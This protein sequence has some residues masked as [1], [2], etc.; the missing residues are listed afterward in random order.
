MTHHIHHVNCDIS[1]QFFHASAKFLAFRITNCSQRIDMFS[2]A[3]Q[4]P[5]KYW[6]LELQF[7]LVL[8]NETMQNETSTNRPSLN[9]EKAMVLFHER[10][11]VSPRIQDMFA[12][13]GPIGCCIWICLSC[14]YKTHFYSSSAIRHIG[15][16]SN[17]LRIYHMWLKIDLPI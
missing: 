6:K 4:F 10:G 7:H 13:I 5:H 16:W 11:F 12:D 1:S 15:I 3:S 9:K 14:E 2:P 17:Y 8:L